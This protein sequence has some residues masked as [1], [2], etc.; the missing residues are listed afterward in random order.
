MRVSKRGQDREGEPG[1]QRQDGQNLE[2]I[3]KGELLG[4]GD[5]NSQ[6]VRRGQVKAGGSRIGSAVRDRK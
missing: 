2:A 1:P 4:A 5:E 3:G 6:Q